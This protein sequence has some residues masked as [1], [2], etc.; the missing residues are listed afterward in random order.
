MEYNNAFGL[1]L[2]YEEL[3]RVPALTPQKPAGERQHGSEAPRVLQ[4][5]TGRNVFPMQGGRAGPQSLGSG[6]AGIYPRS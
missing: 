4:Y 2:K 6:E 5:I 3:H 1:V